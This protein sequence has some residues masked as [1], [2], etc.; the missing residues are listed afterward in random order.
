MNNVASHTGLP[1]PQ[2]SS[3]PL[4]SPFAQLTPSILFMSRVNSYLLFLVTG[5][6]LHNIQPLS[7]RG[8][9]HQELADADLIQQ[10]PIRT[11]NG[12]E[13]ADRPLDYGNRLRDGSQ[14]FQ[15]GGFFSVA[16]GDEPVRVPGASVNVFPGA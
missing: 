2:G 12:A 11:G 10:P 7:L 4:G 14:Y 6:T 8:A 16:A 13:G 3:Y 1:I 15:D 5:R 9:C